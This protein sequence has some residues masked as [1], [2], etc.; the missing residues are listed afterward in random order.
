MFSRRDLS[1]PPSFFSLGLSYLFTNYHSQHAPDGLFA[2]QGAV[3]VRRGHTGPVAQSR[4][5]KITLVAQLLTVVSPTNGARRSRFSVVRPRPSIERARA[6]RSEN[7][8]GPKKRATYQL[9]LSASG[10][11]SLSFALSNFEVTKGSKV[12]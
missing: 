1:S 4:S 3:R 11:E 6:E 7:S 12:R 9:Q 2:L 5:R 10:H 8:A